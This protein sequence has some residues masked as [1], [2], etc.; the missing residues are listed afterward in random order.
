MNEKLNWIRDFLKNFSDRRDNVRKKSLHRGKVCTYIVLPQYFSV[1][2]SFTSRFV[3][4][5]N[6][7]A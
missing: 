3:L 7:L 1:N 5:K 6:I 4:K 2:N